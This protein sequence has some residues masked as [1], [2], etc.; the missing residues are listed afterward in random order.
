MTNDDIW[1]RR[2]RFAGG[3]CCAWRRSWAGA[4]KAHYGKMPSRRRE[5]EDSL[6]ITGAERRWRFFRRWADALSPRQ[7][8]TMTSTCG[9]RGAWLLLAR[10]PGGFWNGAS[11]AGGWRR[12]AAGI[13]CSVVRNAARISM[14]QLNDSSGAEKRRG[15]DDRRLAAA[16]AR[17]LRLRLCAPFWA[18]SANKSPPRW[19]NGVYV[20]GDGGA[21]ANVSR[22]HLLRRQ[23]TALGRRER[24]TRTTY[25]GAV[26]A[27]RRASAWAS[28]C[29]SV[30]DIFAI[31]IR[32]QPRRRDRR[33]R[34]WYSG[35]QTTRP[36]GGW[37]HRHSRPLHV[38]ALLALRRSV[39]R[40]AKIAS[41]LSIMRGI[42][43][44]SSLH[45]AAIWAGSLRESTC[46]FKNNQASER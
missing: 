31:S 15:M 12:S 14:G 22:Q 1:W 38:D 41:R 26:G 11:R 36:G 33:L 2:E 9:W 34:D 7:A 8:A 43:I 25:G 18:F 37:R 32:R 13:S 44:F 4:S 6:K 45:N 46:A 16:T 30:F 27:R 10:K 21:R 39:Q 24:R 40:L 23:M 29:G 42:G 17:L 35:D 5:G 20:G 28:L 19:R 3:N